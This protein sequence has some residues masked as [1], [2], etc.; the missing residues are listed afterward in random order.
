MKNFE[1]SIRLS[2]AETSLNKLVDSLYGDFEIA[3]YEQTNLWQIIDQLSNERFSELKHNAYFA[4][5]LKSLVIDPTPYE[6]S[7]SDDTVASDADA[8][9]AEYGE[10]WTEQASSDGIPVQRAERDE[11]VGDSKITI[12]AF[13]TRIDELRLPDPYSKLVK[14]LISASQ[15]HTSFRIGESFADLLRI[16]VSTLE[17]L[18]G[19]G[20]LY[21]EL[22]KELRN[23]AETSL[24]YEGVP[25]HELPTDS[26]AHSP[27]VDTGNMRLSLSGV[28]SKFAKAIEKYSKHTGGEDLAN[29]LSILLGLERGELVKLPGF[30]VTFIDRLM[31][32]KHRV[33]EELSLIAS[34]KIDYRKFESELISPKVV[35]ALSLERAEDIILEDID[36]FF[37]KIQEDEIDIAQK[38][39]GFVEEKYTLE[40]IAKNYN[41]TRERI[42][43]KE[44]GINK[45]FV[46]QLRINPENF[47]AILEP[48]LTPDIT[49]KLEGLFSC[50]SFE[51]DFYD[52]LSLLTG[53]SDLHKY[54]YPEI[55]KTVLNSYFAEN[56][57]PVTMAD[58]VE[59]LADLN[60]PTVANVGNAISYLEKQGVLTLEDDMV[61][62]QQL[63]KAEASAC[64]LVNHPRGLPWLDVARLVNIRGYSRTPIYEDRLDT[65]AF[66]AP[67]Y[68]FLSGTGTYKHTKFIDTGVLSLDDMFSEIT[69]YARAGQRDVFHLTECHQSSERLQKMDYFELRHFVKHFGEDYG[70]YFDGRSQSDSVGFEKGF[71]NI[72]QRD[73]IIEAM[74]RSDKPMT[75]VEI[76]NL[77]KSRSAGH[78]AFYLDGLM[79]EGKVVQIERM[80]Y[81]T[82]ESAYKN[83]NIEAYVE[84]IGKILADRNK[85]TDPSI[86]Q[87]DLNARF[88]NSYSKNFYASIARLYA[89]RQ[90]WYRQHALYS[91][92]D[93]PFR[94]LT[95]A[96]ALYCRRS[97]S[98]E[99]NVQ[100]LQEHVAITRDSAVIA[101]GNWR[102]AVQ[103]EA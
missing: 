77:L 72:T 84:A 25:S 16:P 88:S 22:F 70:L 3:L 10:Q 54:V 24:D 58:A 91:L 38:R 90:G 13:T 36:L 100:A 86:F 12:P 49:S 101:L 46:R 44:A 27:T 93:I 55:N 5:F 23:L 30:G 6:G 31:A 56:G 51:R 7:L 29:N 15:A 2:Q 69:S 41:I 65:E 42:R 75:K 20:T 92:K 71:K 98:L 81:T 67:D 103:S 18:P 59:Y 1:T 66:K 53:K 11:A 35:E 8:K 45:N 74:N 73:V 64:V 99:E 47:W 62:P 87:L 14:R 82:P 32:L 52:F 85:P 76:A 96:I 78:A 102:N 33:E 80:L 50:F 48:E 28:D 95:G 21:I 37:E 94:N 83:I 9:G 39:W 43:Q 34:G 68:I 57:A 4:D 60:L 97:N 61:W 89:Q 26:V 17:A 63:G 40:E 19:V 79:H